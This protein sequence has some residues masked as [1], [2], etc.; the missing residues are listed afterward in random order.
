MKK[1]QMPKS[2]ATF[3]LTVRL[4]RDLARRL[5]LYAAEQGKTV[6]EITA[7]AL[8]ARLPR[9]VSVRVEY[10]TPKAHTVTYVK[11]GGR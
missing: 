5:R 10:H 8:E 6:Q 1:R 11:E 9:V 2:D 4:P 3:K 7:E